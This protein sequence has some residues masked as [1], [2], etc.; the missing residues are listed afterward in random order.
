MARKAK[1]IE[2]TKNAEEAKVN[3]PVIGYMTLEI[4]PVDFFTGEDMETKTVFLSKPNNKTIGNAMGLMTPKFVGDSVDMIGAG[5]VI[6]M[7]CFVGGDRD[8]LTDDDYSRCAS[9]KLIE[10]I[11]VGE[12]SLKK[13]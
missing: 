13:N 9:L 7:E 5:I 10:L 6:L 2:E 4:T 8:V 11:N 3:A 1:T 12:T